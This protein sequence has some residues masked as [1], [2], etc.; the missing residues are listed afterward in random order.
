MFRIKSSFIL[1]FILSVLLGSQKVMAEAIEQLRKTPADLLVQ[2]NTGG[3]II[4][5]D[6]KLQEAVQLIFFYSED[7]QIDGEAL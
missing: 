6:I 4:V 3:I 5:N 2:N 7:N 1:L